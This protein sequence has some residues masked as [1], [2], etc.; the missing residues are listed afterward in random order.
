MTGGDRTLFDYPAEGRAR[1]SDPETSRAA[2]RTVR[3]HSVRAAIVDAMRHAPDGLTD[4]E[5][6]ATLGVD[7]RRWPTVKTAR[8]ALTHGT[9]AALA[10]TGTTRHG[11]RVW[12]LV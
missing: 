1:R 5:L 7:L 2:A 8:S 4:D 9:P 3:A 11:Q 10:W 6:C 12:R